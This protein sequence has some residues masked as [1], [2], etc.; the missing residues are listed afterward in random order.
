M[1]QLVVERHIDLASDR[2]A[3]WCAASDTERLNRVIGLGRLVL[4]PHT[5]SSAARPTVSSTTLARP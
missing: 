4:T 5:D 3:L 1:A 2:S